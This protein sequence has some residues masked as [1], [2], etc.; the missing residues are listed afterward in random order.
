MSIFFNYSWQIE[1]FFLS[2]N[3][4][5][6]SQFI[7]EFHEINRKENLIDNIQ[8]GYFKQLLRNFFAKS[9]QSPENAIKYLSMISYTIDLRSECTVL[10][11]IMVSAISNFLAQ[12]MNYNH[13]MV[14]K[15]SLAAMLHDIG[16][17]STPINILEKPGKLTNE[18]MEIMREH[19]TI[20]YEILG[21]LGSQEVQEYASY[22]H[23]KLDG[24][25]YPFGLK[26]DQLSIPARIIIVADI[27]GALMAARS[28]K[29]SF[30]KDKIINILSELAAQSKI[31]QSLVDLVIDKYDDFCQ[32]LS[33][34]SNPYHKFKNEYMSIVTKMSP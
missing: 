21:N 18:E 11:T 31:N 24:T 10:H 16:N 32:Y 28:Y 15:I 33:S 4:E 22:H 14:Q 23:E 29:E 6:D 1:D 30:P 3:T 34:L 7:S 13:S 17:I 8:T 12:K 2:L 27:M 19:V 26:K 25:G 5:I 20:T 9:I